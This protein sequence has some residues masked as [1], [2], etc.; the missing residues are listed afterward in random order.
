MQDG[1]IQNMQMKRRS[2]VIICL[3]V[4]F[5]LLA[6]AY[7]VFASFNGSI[8]KKAAMTSRARTYISQ[9]FPDMP[10]KVEFSGY[11]YKICGYYC[12]VR[13]ESSEDTHFLVYE[14]SDGSLTDDYGSRVCREKIL[15]HVLL[16]SWTTIRKSLWGRYSPTE[17][18]L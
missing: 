11:D 12:N 7:C 4:L 2:K 14:D 3:A 17:P 18:L 10:L 1:R 5:V 15:F 6:A 13:S 9:K 16:R 8:I